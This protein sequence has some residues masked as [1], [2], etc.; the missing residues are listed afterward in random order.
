M[1]GALVLAEFEDPAQVVAAVR[2]LRARGFRDLDAHTP[3]A[4]PEIEA[5]LALPSSP[6]PGVVLAA[7]LAGAAATYA[8]EWLLNAHLYPLNAGARPPHFPLSF[9]PI[10]FEMGVLC[11]SLAAVACAFV[12]GRLGRLW[13]PIFE[14]DGF[15]RAAIDRHWLEVRHVE[16]A[17]LPELEHVLRVHEPRAIVRPGDRA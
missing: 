4:V 9:V 1:T 16:T 3:Y 6:L 5:A 2:A 14:V 15:E 7:G 8:L 12:L 17:R 13:Q 10:A 11:A